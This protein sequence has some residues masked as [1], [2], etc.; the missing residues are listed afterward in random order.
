MYPIIRSIGLLNVHIPKC[1]CSVHCIVLVL[2]YWRQ[3]SYVCTVYCFL[4]AHNAPCYSTY[5]LCTYCIP[6][7]QGL[8]RSFWLLRTKYLSPLHVSADV[9]FTGASLLW[10]LLFFF[11][12]N[13]AFNCNIIFY[14][15]IWYIQPVRYMLI[16]YQCFINS[17]FPCHDLVD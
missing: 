1:T 7:S 15:L 6:P 10:K 16:S 5:I 17:W 4:F 11:T 8:F 2:D 14:K 13:Y 12:E 3:E 9:S